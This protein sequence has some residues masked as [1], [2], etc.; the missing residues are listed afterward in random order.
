MNSK[1]VVSLWISHCR[2]GVGPQLRC[3]LF[4]HPP[5]LIQSHVY[6]MSCA[7]EEEKKWLINRSLLSGKFFR[8]QKKVVALHRIRCVL[9]NKINDSCNTARRIKRQFYNEIA[10]KIHSELP[11]LDVSISLIDQIARALCSH[12]S[13]IWASTQVALRT[14]SN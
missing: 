5:N 4:I 13:R 3:L 9:P 14:T 1:Q 7:A 8:N 6:W 12:S 10:H 2:P 11:L